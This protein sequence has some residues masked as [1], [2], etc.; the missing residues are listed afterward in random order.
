MKEEGVDSGKVS[1]RSFIK[2]SAVGVGA[3]TVAGSGLLPAAAAAAP[4]PAAGPE[5]PAVIPPIPADQIAETATTDIAVVGLGIAGMCATLSAVD[6]GAKVIA[7][8]KGATHNARGFD[9]G[10]VN[11]SVHREA[12]VLY[13]REEIISELMKQANY[14]VDQR[15]IT[16]WVDQ[17]GGVIDWLRSLVEPRGVKASLGGGGSEYEG[18]Y[19]VYHTAVNWTGQNARLMEEMEKIVRERGADLRYN[20]A[21]AKLIREGDG[22]VTGVI[23][24]REDGKY[25]RIDARKGVILC[26]GGYDNSPEMMRRYLRPSDLRIERF[27]S[28]N[29]LC[30][31]D[32]HNM[33]LDVGAEID[34]APHCMIVGNGIINSKD[35][36]YLVMFTPWLRVDALGRRYVNEDS[37]YCRS[38]NANAR[39]PR[40]FNWS[41]LD[42]AWWEG[43][44][45]ESQYTQYVRRQMDK[46][47]RDGVVL[48]ADTLEELAAK[49]QVPAA[50]LTATVARYNQLAK[51]GKDLD[52]GVAAE[53]MKPVR[54]APFFAMEVRNFCLV[55]VSGLRINEQMQVLD[56]QGEIIPGLYAAGNTSGGFF[57]DTYPRNVHGIS[58]GRA[59]TFGRLA[60]LH[61]AARQ[62]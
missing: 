53:K 1:R 34:E 16:V 5:S 18:P 23:A 21:G 55:T 60:A 44:Q 59:I 7:I 26:S 29:K 49:M 19:R 36:F 3:V 32:G 40:H 31:G 30:T 57:S 38:A 27:N 39:L 46:Y 54:K 58:H 45:A 56:R 10:C 50:N 35:E 47:V 17:S 43:P 52:F 9:D 24:R 15:L 2:G 20:T 28:Q 6:A 41:I 42:A 8:E 12:G 14:R 33:G 13:D 11:S 51:D 62:A 4:G 61:A 37:D 25:V 22:P 48:T